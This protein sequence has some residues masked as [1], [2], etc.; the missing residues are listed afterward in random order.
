M[1][2]YARERRALDEQRRLEEAD[3]IRRNKK[4]RFAE[5]E[6]DPR[7]ARDPIQVPIPEGAKYALYKDPMETDE[8]DDERQQAD[9]Y[10]KFDVMKRSHRS[11]ITG[12][13]KQKLLAD[14]GHD[15]K[16]SVK[17]ELDKIRKAVKIQQDDFADQ[18]TRVQDE[19]EKAIVERNRAHN[20]LDRMRQEVHV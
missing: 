16:N 9:E 11:A 13:T 4:A 7:V 17:Y 20:N 12:M 3:E 18:I 6:P 5:T 10:N 14:I 1:E 19:C 8:Y 15:L 2:S